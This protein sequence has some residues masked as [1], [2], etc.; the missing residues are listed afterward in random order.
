MESE[1]QEQ[2][3]KSISGD[4]ENKLRLLEQNNKE[5]EE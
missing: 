5:S 3:R 1:I 2:L 4:Y